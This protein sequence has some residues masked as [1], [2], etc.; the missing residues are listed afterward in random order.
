M[1]LLCCSQLILTV[2]NCLYS[3]K[4][5]HLLLFLCFRSAIDINM[6]HTMSIISTVRSF[7]LHP[8]R[9]S[10]HP[11]NATHLHVTLQHTVLWICCAHTPYFALIV[12]VYGWFVL[13]QV[14]QDLQ[15]LHLYT[16]PSNTREERDD[17]WISSRRQVVFCIRYSAGGGCLATRVLTFGQDAT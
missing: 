1:S 8:T 10:I 16:D 9:R 2:A 13:L 3:I 12:F 4:F 7:L 6:L 17:L 14:L 5:I 15:P 11:S